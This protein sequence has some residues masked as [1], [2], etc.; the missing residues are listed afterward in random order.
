MLSRR[1]PFAAAFATLVAF[2]PHAT[3]TAQAIP[4][5]MSAQCVGQSLGCSQVD[6]FLH[7]GIGQSATLDVFSLE[8]TSPGW[9]F[10]DPN[11]SESED[12]EGNDPFLVPDILTPR[13]LVADFMFGAVV[14]DL[15]PL[16]MRFEVITAQA[17]I[18]SLGVRYS[19]GPRSDPD[20]VFGR[21]G[22]TAVPEPQSI[23]LLAAGLVALAYLRARRRSH[24]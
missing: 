7:L 10:F 1:L 12:S 4:S 24:V 20:A 23:A 11:Q 3:A 15:A 5:T 6:F 13:H 17:D 16:R 19:G 22:A 14:N 9:S 21:F 8:L 2:V 18:S